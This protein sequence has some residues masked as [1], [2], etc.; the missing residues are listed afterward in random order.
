MSEVQVNPAPRFQLNILRLVAAVFYILTGII[1]LFNPLFQSLQGY[2]NFLSSG[3]SPFVLAE[4]HL[5]FVS[6]SLPLAC[7][8]LAVTGVLAKSGKI[9][10]WAAGAYFLVTVPMSWLMTVLWENQS[11]YAVDLTHWQVLWTGN[12]LIDSSV[13]ITLSLASAL[14]VASLFFNS[15]I[16][17]SGSSVAS[18]PVPTMTAAPVAG[19]AS[20]V[21]NLPIFAL[22]G[23]FV[24]PLAGIILGHISINQM[25]KG[26]ISNQNR[27]LAMAGLILGYVFIAL[28][29][30]LGVLIAVALIASRS[31]YYY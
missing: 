27:G 22:V 5:L 23:A 15:S 11:G 4:Y 3:Q 25:N 10:I 7:L 13:T 30:L 24:V 12:D 18:Q 29:I 20:Q 14:G 9:W 17:P 26:M 6:L 1:S 8:A 31:S 2:L 19:G 21:S 28:S 16:R